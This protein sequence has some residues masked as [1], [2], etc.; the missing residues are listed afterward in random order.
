MPVFEHGERTEQQDVRPALASHNRPT[1][2]AVAIAYKGGSGGCYRSVG[3]SRVLS[4]ALQ[5]VSAIVES[6][7]QRLST[8][9]A[10]VLLFTAAPTA[11]ATPRARPVQ[12]EPVIV[13]IRGDGF[14]WGDAAIGAAAAFGLTL[15][16]G[17]VLLLTH[18]GPPRSERNGHA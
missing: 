5:V 1:V 16:A 11:A 7:T 14:H 2:N 4:S 18:N 17:G 9:I 13:Q 6:M 3:E 10:S 12:K 8:A 15:A